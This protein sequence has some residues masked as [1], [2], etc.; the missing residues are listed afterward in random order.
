[1]SDTTNGAPAPA[2]EAEEPMS[3]SA[4]KRKLKASRVV[5][6]CWD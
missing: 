1:M 5:V 3:K 6:V 4:L 2:V